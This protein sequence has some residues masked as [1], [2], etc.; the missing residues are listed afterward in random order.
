MPPARYAVGWPETTWGAVMAAQQE[1]LERLLTLTVEPSSVA[2]APGVEEGEQR[3][4][5]SPGPPDSEKGGPDQPPIAE[6]TCP[7]TPPTEAPGEHAASDSE[8]DTDS[9]SSSTTSS[10]SSS[11]SV[12]SDDD[13]DHPNE[14]DNR[15]HCVRTKDELPLDELPPV[16]DL[17]VILPDNV[18][19][20]LF[21][22]VS[23]IIE[24]L[25]IIESLRGL[26]PINEESI[27]FK[28]DRQAAGKVFEVFGPVQHPF[29]VLRF[30]SSEHI[31]ARGI[32]VKDNMYF[33]P[34]VEDFTQYIFAEKL[35]Q[36]KGS[37]ASW[38]NDQEP[39]PE[40]LDFSDD[41]KEREA[42]QKKKK[43]QNQGRK[44]VKTD[45]NA[46]SEYKGLNQPVQQPASSYS[47]GYHGRR[48]SGDPFPSPSGPP[49]FPR[50][51]I[52][53]PHLYSSDSRIHQESPVFPQ[54]HRKEHP[55]MQQY[56][57]PPPVFGSVNEMHQFHLPPSNPNMIWT[58]P[59]MYNSYPF[60]PP[61][62]PPPPPPPDSHPQFRPY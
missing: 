10:S 55:M 15:T 20:K 23:S 38:K 14:K 21:G 7:S 24:Q 33:A 29:Y 53:P 12:V 45:T 5:N 41:E 48:F 42:K 13:D 57:F 3:S 31:K 60:L 28:E 17:N 49:G 36:E 22:T 43:P 54:P 59:N 6:G 18:E 8:S 58:G 62:Q 16:E 19:L 25:V 51:P 40:A 47:R 46:S 37:D 2:E 27:I 4:A 50:P 44:K 61:P 56:P 30:N 26:P 32:N 1:V 34:S 9:D 35:Q 52:R 39:P 11:P